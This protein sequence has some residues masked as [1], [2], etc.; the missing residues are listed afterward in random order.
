[1]CSLSFFWLLEI[2]KETVRGKQAAAVAT[3][4]DVINDKVCL[5]RIL[6]KVMQLV[7]LLEH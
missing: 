4:A 5:I 1:M 3:T 2:V 6:V 7:V